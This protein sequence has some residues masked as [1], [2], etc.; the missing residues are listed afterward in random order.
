LAPAKLNLAI[1]LVAIVV[2]A[3]VVAAITIAAAQRTPR[4][5]SG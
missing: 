5:A 2:V 3:I 1:F 4:E